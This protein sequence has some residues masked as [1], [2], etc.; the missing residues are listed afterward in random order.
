LMQGQALGS[1]WFK[2]AISAATGVRRARLR[3][4]RPE[5]D[6]ESMRED[7]TDFGF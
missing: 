1:E 2:E 7:Q 5:K 3:R 6:S 4:G